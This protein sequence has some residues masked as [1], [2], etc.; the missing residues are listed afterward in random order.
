[1]RTKTTTNPLF[2]PADATLSV[3]DEARFDAMLHDQRSVDL[4][5][6]NV[7]ASLARHRDQP[8]LAERLRMFAG[9]A[10]R[11]PVRLS[12]WTGRDREP[13]L[14]P[15]AA[16]LAAA[17]ERMRNAGAE[18]GALEAALSEVRRPAEVPV[19]IDSPD[20]L[21]LVDTC[22]TELPAGVGG[23]DRLVELIDAGID[24][25]ARVGKQLAVAV[26]YP[27]GTRLGGDI[28]ARVNTLRANLKA[29]LPHRDRV[30]AV[31]LREVTWQQLLK[32]WE[33]E[34]GWMDLDGQ[35]VKQ[36]LAHC[37]ALGL[38]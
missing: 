16:Y 28:S 30:G 25:A 6:W 12:L 24:Q 27:S 9:D 2:F 37:S 7:F 22:L 5:T 34:I 21:G 14:T 23:R 13:R 4:L 31:A 11:P 1:M 26:V 19:R 20:V 29:E 35:P 3:A 18:G 17:R 32:V 36:F 15:N 10:V 33:S 38:R 8:W